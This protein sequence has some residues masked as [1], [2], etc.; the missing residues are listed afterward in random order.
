MIGSV[1]TVVVMFGPPGSGKGTQAAKLQAEVGLEHLST[2]DLLRAE[3]ARGGEL[4]QAMAAGELLPD[5]LIEGLVEAWLDAHETAP[6]ALLDGFPRTLEQARA[7]D[8]MLARRGRRVDLVLA[9][10]VAEGE[11]QRRILERA[12]EQGR[13][14][15][16]PSAIRERMLE[17]HA[18]TEPVLGHYRAAGV[19]VAAIAGAGPPDE[20]FQRIRQAWTAAGL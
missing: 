7:L 18:R 9:L 20:V 13:A 2:G 8:A 10:E 11:L 12:S 15:D 5:R 14:D 19:P 4:A 17:Y 3:A 1:P 16:T 6:G